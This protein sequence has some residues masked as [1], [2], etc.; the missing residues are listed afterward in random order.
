MYKCTVVAIGVHLLRCI[1]FFGS[2][3]LNCLEIINGLCNIHVEKGSRGCVSNIQNN[4]E[5]TER[6]KPFYVPIDNLAN[7]KFILIYR[8]D[9]P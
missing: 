7:R 5:N 4:N 2:I 3:I 1:I 8:E 9:V 6:L